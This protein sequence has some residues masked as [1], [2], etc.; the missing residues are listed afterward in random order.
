MTLSPTGESCTNGALSL[1]WLSVGRS[2]AVDWASTDGRW[3]GPLAGST[4]TAVCEIVMSVGRISMK[5]SR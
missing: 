2:M 5:R 1:S 4:S 3:S